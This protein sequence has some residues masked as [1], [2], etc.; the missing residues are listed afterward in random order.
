MLVKSLINLPCSMDGGENNVIFVVY[1]GQI[2]SYLSQTNRKLSIS[3]KSEAI[4]LRQ[5]VTF[6]CKKQMSIL[7][8]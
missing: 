1:L 6:C 5:I 2:G 7:D 4:Y 8:K 3:D